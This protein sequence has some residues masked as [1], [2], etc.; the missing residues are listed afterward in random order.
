MKQIKNLYLLLW[1]ITMACL[2]SCTDDLGTDENRSI[3]EGVPVTVHLDFNV[4]QS[5]Q[6]TRIAG[7]AEAERTVNTLN[8]FVF[9]SDG[10]LDAKF[11]FDI[12]GTDGK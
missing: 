5:S 9:D 12:N 4:G 11:Q 3:K 2:P 10:T 6:V 1:M 8:V 7:S